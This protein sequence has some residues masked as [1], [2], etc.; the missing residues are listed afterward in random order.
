MQ[1]YTHLFSLMLLFAFQTSFA[2]DQP[3]KTKKKGIIYLSWGYNRETYSKSDIRFQNNGSDNYDFV[4]QNATA[5][6]KPGF[7]HGLKN[8]LKT[9]LTIP[10]YNFRLGYLFNDDHHLGIEL[11]WDHLKYIV[12]D[13]VT[14]HLKGQ[15]RG[16][17]IDKDTFITYDFIHLQHTNGNNYAMLNITKQHQLYKNRY[18]DVQAIGKAGAGP[19]VS[20]SISKVLGSFDDDGFKIQGF[21]LGLNLGARM[22]LFKYLFIQPTFQYAFADYTNTRVAADRSG[23]VTH[24]FSSYM[25]S[26]EGG[27]NIPLESV[28]SLRSQ[29]KP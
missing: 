27:F 26:V 19:L 24:M 13:N 8:F 1:Y 15:I 4:Y 5:H 23:K 18:I 9:D 25:V 29:K 12:D 2:Q 20:Y 11:S 7:N 6:E 17:S 14:R 3:V 21:V 28:A 22:N 10:Q 16:N